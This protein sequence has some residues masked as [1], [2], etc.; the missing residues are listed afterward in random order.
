M[1]LRRHR[2]LSDPTASTLID[3]DCP[4]DALSLLKET[5]FSND[6]M[7]TV[8]ALVHGSRSANDIVLKFGSDDISQSDLRRLDGPLLPKGKR[9]TDIWLN[10]KLLSYLLHI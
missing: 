8:M 5:A 2:Q 3:I 9:N 1:M 4:V 7:D 10:D 6:C